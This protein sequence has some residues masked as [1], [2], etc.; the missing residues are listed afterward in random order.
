PALPAA[1]RR[2]SADRVRSQATLADPRGDRWGGGGLG[3]VEYPLHRPVGDPRLARTRAGA[4]SD[5]LRAGHAIRA[6][7]LGVRALP[8]PARPSAPGCRD[9]RG[10]ARERRAARRPAHSVGGAVGRTRRRLRSPLRRAPRGES[11]GGPV[12]AAPRPRRPHPGGGAAGR[13]LAPG[14]SERSG[15]CP[16]RARGPLARLPRRSADHHPAGAAPSGAPGGAAAGVG[17]ARHLARRPEPCLTMDNLTHAF[18][19]IACTHAVSR[20]RPCGL[21]LAAAV[22]AANV[23]DLDWLPV[24]S[25]RPE[26][27]EAHRGTMH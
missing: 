4:Q 25:L 12:S 20:E 3:T 11:A 5:D 15:A 22:L 17:G 18:T 27:I 14:G 10:R 9:G 7:E 19:A 24:L 26:S 13:V 8:H 6:A 21:T 1:A 16:R 2:R 23:Q